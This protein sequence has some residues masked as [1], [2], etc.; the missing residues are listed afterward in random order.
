MKR[1]IQPAGYLAA[2]ALLLCAS[3]AMPA[4]AAADEA[5]AAPETAAAAEAAPKLTLRH[6]A[7][8][9]GPLILTPASTATSGEGMRVV[10]DEKT[11]KLRAA[12]A[13]ELQAERSLAAS[14]ATSRFERATAPSQIHRADGS[15]VAEVPA[16]LFSYSVVHVGADGETT[17]R[18]ADAHS[19]DHEHAEAAGREV[20]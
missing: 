13:G 10:I 7:M 2:M 1:S 15:V 3:L 20:R 11:G 16:E 14:R 4:A 5:E 12:T 6:A 17:F 9:N 18:C 19:A 8:W